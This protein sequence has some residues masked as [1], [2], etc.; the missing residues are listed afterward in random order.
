MYADVHERLTM[1]DKSDVTKPIVRYK[2]Q[3]DQFQVIIA[4]SDKWRSLHLDNDAINI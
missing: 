3:G 2:F 1:L 4:C